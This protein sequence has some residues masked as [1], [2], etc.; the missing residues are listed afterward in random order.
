MKT[1]VFD[2]AGLLAPAA[3]GFMGFAVSILSAVT[4]L[5]RLVAID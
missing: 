3:A 5:N 1:S 2:A 4:R